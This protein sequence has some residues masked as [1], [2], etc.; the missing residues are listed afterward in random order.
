MLL[1]HSCISNRSSQPENDLADVSAVCIC[2]F[3][4]NKCVGSSAHTPV[5]YTHMERLS[6]HG[7]DSSH[8]HGCDGSKHQSVPKP[9]RGLI[10]SLVL[11]DSKP[12]S[13]R[14]HVL[15]SLPLPSKDLDM[16]F[17]LLPAWLYSP[18]VNLL[19]QNYIATHCGLPLWAIHI[20][21]W[22][23]DGSGRRMICIFPNNKTCCPFLHIDF[24]FTSS[25]LIQRKL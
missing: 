20:I 21:K 16:P 7:L 2:D 8:F 9:S 12:T 15:F 23:T 5:K 10:H 14:I 11:C 24:I 3:W 1:N 22:Q 6:S 25:I 19:Q 17:D 18:M 4:L 13:L